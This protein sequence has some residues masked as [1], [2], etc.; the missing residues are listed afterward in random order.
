MLIF[1]LCWSLLCPSY[2]CPDERIWTFFCYLS[3]IWKSSGFPCMIP[4][5]LN[6]SII[7]YYTEISSN[8]KISGLCYFYKLGFSGWVYG[9]SFK[10]T[11]VEFF[12]K[13]LIVLLVNLWIYKLLL[14]KVLHNKLT[15]K[16]E[17]RLIMISLGFIFMPKYELPWKRP[18]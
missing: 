11:R 4:L 17:D 2:L 6:H 1:L 5:T 16:N 18:K 8:D 7:L 15:K 12:W 9:V 10:W 14:G 3:F 13:D